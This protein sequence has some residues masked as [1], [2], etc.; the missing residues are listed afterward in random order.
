MTR[1]VKSS[2]FLGSIL[3]YRPKSMQ[4]L[5]VDEESEIDKNYY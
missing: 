5:F 4:T 1:K 3:R 2:L